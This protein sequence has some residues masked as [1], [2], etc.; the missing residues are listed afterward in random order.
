MSLCTWRRLRGGPVLGT[1]RAGAGAAAGV[2]GWGCG[3]GREVSLETRVREGDTECVGV[4]LS[5]AIA[6]RRCARDGRCTDIAESRV[7]T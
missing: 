3:G 6:L 4:W 1:T 7:Q 2:G 5:G